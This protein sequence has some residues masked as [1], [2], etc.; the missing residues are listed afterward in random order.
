MAW[1]HEV[2]WLVVGSGAAGLSAAVRGHALG[3]DVLVVE[4]SEQI[5][6]STAISGGVVWVPG[7]DQMA[8]RG[9]PDS[10]EDALTYL[11]VVTKGEVAE[12][13]L[14]AYVEHAPRMQA[15]MAQHTHLK[16]DALERYADYYPEAPGGRPGGR[17]MEPVI[18]DG[19]LLGPEFAHL[20]RPHP[21]SQVMG[22]FGISARQAHGFLAPTPKDTLLLAWLFLL[23]FLRAW[24]R[25]GQPRDTRLHAG[26]ALV[27][28]LLRS[29]M[30]RGVP[31]WREAP[32]T[33]LVLEG[34]RVVGAVI[35][36]DGAPVRV[37]ARRGVLLGAGG[38]EQ[39]QAWR[40]E[41]H[42]Y[43]ESRVAWN[44]GNPRNQGDGIR[45]G[46]DAGGALANMKEAWWT[47]VTRV[48]RSDPAWVLVVEKSLPGSLFVN[49]AGRRFTNEAAPYEDVVRGM[50]AGDAVP[51]CWMVFD[52]ECRRLYPV[53]PTAPGYAQP[54]E[55][56][57]RRLREGFFTIAPTLE[58]LAVK[59]ELDPSVFQG[60]VA[61]Y[62]EFCL[63]GKDGDFG[64]GDSASDRYYGDRRVTP[65]PC[66]RPLTHAPYYAIPIFPGELGTKGGLVTDPSAR[67]LREDGTPIPGLFAAGNT[68]AAV[69]GPSY[70]GA[71][72]TI[73]PALTFGML[74]AEAA[75]G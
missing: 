47:P 48:P 25:R 22:R 70:P 75:A 14:R 58:E 16:L 45:M 32:C 17:S 23:W 8:S 49:G 35:E 69:M 42:R 62:N 10:P 74:A 30:D 9:I 50:Y 52:A 59:L 53:G 40:D 55:R 31:I 57:S 71:G 65:N 56:L 72:G 39:N 67:V 15:W 5:G 41:H 28:R 6:G 13:R 61:R 44:T 63:A 18:F 27:A 20:R 43:G 68:T 11:G 60:T 38:F 7:N 1:D 26:N 24:K 12:D 29:L 2:D 66:L 73:G 33:E 4:A 54:D 51:V 46:R 64:R 36:R 19:A 3:M 21:Q 37:A 34:G